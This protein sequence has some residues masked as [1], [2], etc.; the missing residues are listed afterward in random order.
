MPGDKPG[1]WKGLAVDSVPG[2]LA[3]SRFPTLSFQKT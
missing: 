1:M 2:E 3:E